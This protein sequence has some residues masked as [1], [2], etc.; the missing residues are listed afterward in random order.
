MKCRKQGNQIKFTTGEFN[1]NMYFLPCT[2]HKSAH[3]SETLRLCPRRPCTGRWFHRILKHKKIASVTERVMSSVSK[4]LSA[5]H[6]V[7]EP[8]KR[9]HTKA[10]CFLLAVLLDYITRESGTVL[11]GV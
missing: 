11:L 7:N 9:K 10:V 3:R 1:E 2:L 5:Y 4:E 8:I 6:S